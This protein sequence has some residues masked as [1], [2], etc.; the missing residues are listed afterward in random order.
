M[1]PAAAPNDP[2]L[3]PWIARVVS[4]VSAT[5][6][7][8]VYS[9]MLPSGTVDA[10]ASARSVFEQLPAG[11][12][13]RHATRSSAGRSPYITAEMLTWTIGLMLSLPAGE[14]TNSIR[15]SEPRVC[16]LASGLI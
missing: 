13:Q 11:T 1:D 10:I 5:S 7:R 9:D 6:S 14:S 16:R 2:Y 3:S 8:C 15:H 4:M 12:S